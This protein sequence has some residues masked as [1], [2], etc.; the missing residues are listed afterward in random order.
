MHDI[1]FVSCTSLAPNAVGWYT[2]SDQLPHLLP[3]MQALLRSYRPEVIASLGSAVLHLLEWMDSQL[4][5]A[6]AQRGSTQWANTAQSKLTTPTWLPALPVLSL[7]PLMGQGS[8][9]GG[10]LARRLVC[11]VL[12]L[13]LPA[14]RL[15][16]AWL[17]VLP[18]E[19]VG[20]RVVRPLVAYA[21]KHVHCTC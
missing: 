8:S 10:Q 19:V 4:H 16:A 2:E 1:L 7:C 13:P 21:G 12:G 3:C 5:A 15:L 18:A 14:Q 6:P 9:I 17:L 11:D 20:A